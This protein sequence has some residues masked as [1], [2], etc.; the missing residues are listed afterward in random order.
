MYDFRLRKFLIGIF[1][2]DFVKISMFLDFYIH[3]MVNKNTE[4]VKKIH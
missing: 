4:L 3:K 2:C 1:I